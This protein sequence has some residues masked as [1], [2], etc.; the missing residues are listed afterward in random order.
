MIANPWLK[1]VPNATPS[2]IL[3]AL[4]LVEKDKTKIWV[5]SPNSEIKIRINEIIN[6]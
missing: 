2:S 1:R 5:L 3:V 4:F 6:G